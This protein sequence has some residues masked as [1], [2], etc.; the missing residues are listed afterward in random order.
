MRH[1]N[2]KVLITAAIIS[3]IGLTGLGLNQVM[4]QETDNPMQTLVQKIAQRF[5]LNESDVQSVFDDHRSQMH[6]QM[7]VRFEEKLNQAVADG[8]ITQDQKQL[9]LDKHQELQ[10]QREADSQA[11]QSLN[12]DDRRTQMQQKHQELLEWANVNDIDLKFLMGFGFKG[13]HMHMM[14]RSNRPPEL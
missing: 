4:A 10:N 3:G 12:P 11:W 2:K 5:S 13:G 1:M 14:G 8:V 7:Q 6:E 9:I